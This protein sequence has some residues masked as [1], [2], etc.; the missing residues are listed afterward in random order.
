MMVVMV[1]KC[2]DDGGGVGSGAG[3]CGSSG[4]RGGGGFDEGGLGVG[5]GGGSCGLLLHRTV[6]SKF[7]SIFRAAEMA[8][9][10]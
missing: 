9:N 1:T 10:V 8:S 5:D 7:W 2:D 6:S 3:R 4:E